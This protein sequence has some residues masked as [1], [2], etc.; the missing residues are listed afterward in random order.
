MKI[1]NVIC[2]YNLLLVP[3]KQRI[4]LYYLKGKA[5]DI[6]PDYSKY[7]EEALTKAVKISNILR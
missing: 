1:K 3:K 5:S 6:L 2:D 7:A 4:E